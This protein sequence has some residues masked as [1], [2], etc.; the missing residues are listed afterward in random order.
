MERYEGRCHC[1]S[2]SFEISVPKIEKGLRCNCSICERKGAVMTPF[3]I[4]PENL[5]FEAQND[6]LSTYQFGTDVA[7]HHFCNK[8]GIYTFHETMR[9]P[10]HYRVNIGC[11]DGLQSLELPVETFDG[12]SI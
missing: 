2:V 10:G 4:A 12:A 11:I 3:T 9:I 1:G 8:C 6:S 5:K 7:R